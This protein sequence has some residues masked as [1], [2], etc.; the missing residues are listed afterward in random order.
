MRGTE[1][2]S[3][4]LVSCTWMWAA[5]ACDETVAC[6]LLLAC[7]VSGPLTCI[8]MQVALLTEVP[9]MNT[10]C[11]D[12]KLPF[13]CSKILP[14]STSTM[15]PV[16]YHFPEPCPFLHVYIGDEARARCDSGD[17]CARGLTRHDV[18]QRIQP[19]PLGCTCAE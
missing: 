5:P 3:S 14:E 8:T 12:T 18:Q 6:C 15:C 17:A 4:F 11:I 9:L 10:I 13:F 1:R 19:F 16:F 2:I 7:L